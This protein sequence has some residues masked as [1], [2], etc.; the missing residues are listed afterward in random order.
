[1]GKNSGAKQGKKNRIAEQDESGSSFKNSDIKRGDDF[2]DSSSHERKKKKQRKRENG[3]IFDGFVSTS[4]T[5]GSVKGGDVDGGN[6]R[7]GRKKRKVEQDIDREKELEKPM[8][9]DK[10][11]S[12]LGKGPNAYPLTSKASEDGVT[13]KKYEKETYA[14]VD[15]YDITCKSKGVK[16]KKRKKERKHN[17]ADASRAVLGEGPGDMEVSQKKKEH[18]KQDEG[19]DTTKQLDLGYGDNSKV[20]KMNKQEEKDKYKQEKKENKSKQRNGEKKNKEREEEESKKEKLA[21]EKTRK[22]RF[23]DNVEVF[24]SPDGPSKRNAKKTNQLVQGKRFSPEEDALIKEA[25]HRFVED[26]GL[27][28]NGVSMVLHCKG[29]AETRNCWKEIGAALPWRPVVSVYHRAHTLFERSETRSWTEEEREIIRKFHEKHGADWKTLADVMG[30][31]RVHVKD[32]WRRIKLRNMNKGPWNQEEYQTL[33]DL[34]NMDL[35]MRAL[36][37]K[38]SNHKIIR[39]NISWEAISQKLS[40][41]NNSSCCSKWYDQLTSSMVAEGLWADADDYWLLN[42]LVGLDACSMEEVD[43]D[44]LIEHRGGDVCRKRWGQMVKHIGEHGK[45]SFV[46]QVEILSERYCPNLVQMREACDKK[47]L[48]N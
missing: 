23:A 12:R 34:V 42:A 18:S 22:V 7:E 41:R 48:G 24:P 36:E 11:S 45:R 47:R 8:N 39:D 9:K 43:W 26:R 20:E 10:K 40:T 15:D 13:G 44:S 33:F 25:V 35:Q 31:H 32:A 6:K 28:E 16:S 46:E 3:G 4:N 27:G 30:K 1:M 17:L 2:V 37:E 38:V 29:H 21:K 14:P 5:S 19:E